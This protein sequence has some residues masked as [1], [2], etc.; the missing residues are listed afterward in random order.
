MTVMGVAKKL[1][2]ERVSVGLTSDDDEEVERLD[3]PTLGKQPESLK[4]HLWHGNLDR[5]LQ[6]IEDLECDQDLPRERLER[7]KKLRK[8]VSEFRLY[9][10]VN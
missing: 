5:A 3:V 4:W 2:L 7:T 1:A 9:I 10:A 8:A 6:I